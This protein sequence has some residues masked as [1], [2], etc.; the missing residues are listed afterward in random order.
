MVN[1]LTQNKFVM[2]IAKR[3]IRANKRTTAVILTTLSLIFALFVMMLG[4]RNIFRDVFIKEAEARY[5]YADLI[6]S[7]D[8]YSPARLINKRHLRDYD[9]I[10]HALAFFNLQVLTSYE[11]DMFYGQLFSSL[12]HEFEIFMDHEISISGNEMMITDA[13]AKEKGVAVGDSITI[14]LL[15]K[16]LT[17]QVSSVMKEHA[18]FSGTSFFIDKT[19]LLE[20]LYGL[21][22]LSNF[23]NVVYIKTTQSE[24]LYQAL[25]TD[26]NYQ[27]YAIRYAVDID[28]IEQLITEQISMVILAGF[29]VLAALI[30]VLNSLFPIVLKDIYQEIGVF[31]TLGDDRKLGYW[32]CFYQW[33][34]YASISFI[35]GW[36]LAQIVVNISA[37]IYG[38]NA[39]L[40]IDLAIVFY[41]VLI[42]FGIIILSNFFLMRKYYQKEMI[43]KIKDRRYVLTTIHTAL[44]GLALVGLIVFLSF[45]P[46]TPEYNAL[47]IV[48][49]SLYVSLNLTTLLLKG[50]GKLFSKSKTT[51]SLFQAKHMGDNKNI[52]QS[53]NVIFI[54]FIVVGIMLTTRF[55]I[56]KQI[57]EVREM[58]QF[59][60]LMLNIH[61]YNDAII[62][63]LLTY[64]VTDA[65][66]GMFYQHITAYTHDNQFLIIMFVS[67]EASKFNQFYGYDISAV[68]PDVLALDIPY[69]ML[70]SS[71]E[72]V[73][74][75]KAG[76]RLHIDLSPELRQVEFVVGGFI[77][78]DFDQVVYTNLAE[79]PAVFGVNYNAVIM[80]ANNPQ[81][82]MNVL[83]QNFGGRM[84]YLVDAQ[85]AVADKLAQ[86]ENILVFFTVLTVFVIFSFLMVVFNNT[87]LKFAS[88][89]ADYA[90]IK[91]LGIS[92]QDN[93]KNLAKEFFILCGVLLVVGILEVIV[94][95]VYLKD[96]L[97]FFDYY[98][99]MTA[100]IPGVLIAFGLVFLSLLISY[101]A[102]F[103]QI[104]NIFVSE[105]IRTI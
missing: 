33:V 77:P 67:T 32:V 105:E 27:N 16:T 71:Y 8:E 83:I 36:I 93:F 40:L 19:S 29:I 3:N 95:S 45:K 46:L 59:N 74:H 31:E 43:T 35:I 22:Q 52:H 39:F 80:N 100:S 101:W 10:E 48:G 66:P 60:F 6:I 84:F 56:S 92:N 55:F 89:K 7:Y 57:D 94:L 58:H 5:P 53:L 2:L 75:L 21:S 104:S 103:V 90:K 9:N 12:P 97:L 65:A 25:K 23:G 68:S 49:L 37:I 99:N 38:L 76:D 87:R 72:K 34:V 13:F 24:A 61:D 1:L 41:S 85:A 18:I 81:E 20:S 79:K 28:Q 4:V 62:D 98:K 14:D 102:Y 73:Y 50:Y 86:V 88:L 54:A 47:M 44:L 15:G 17:Y 69:V 42:L 11:G 78:T 64:D 70:P 51:F 26:T 96:M 82:T 63:E 91:V 30:I